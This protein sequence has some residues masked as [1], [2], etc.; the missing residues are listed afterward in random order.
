MQTTTSPDGGNLISVF[1]AAAG[2][3]G[4]RPGCRQLRACCR[5]RSRP[6]GCEVLFVAAPYA[7]PLGRLRTYLTDRAAAR[8]RETAT[9]VL[10]A[11]I[12]RSGEA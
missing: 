9:E 11:L 1:S 8:G 5:R 12:M 2:A 4:R 10:D 3:A 7:G 6:H